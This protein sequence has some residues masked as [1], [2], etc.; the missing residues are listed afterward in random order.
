MVLR[1]FSFFVNCRIL[2]SFACT[3]YNNVVS[4]QSCVIDRTKKPATADNNNDT[5]MQLVSGL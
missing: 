1:L 4:I 3:Y 2:V 5:N